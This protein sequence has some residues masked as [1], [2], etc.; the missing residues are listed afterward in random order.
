MKQKKIRY[1]IA[2]IT[3]ATKCPVNIAVFRYIKRN[4]KA[5]KNAV[6]CNELKAL[7]IDDTRRTH[8]PGR[9]P[10]FIFS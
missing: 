7:K 9:S 3:K 4:G 1:T 6:I 2:A 8:F 10:Y 5:A